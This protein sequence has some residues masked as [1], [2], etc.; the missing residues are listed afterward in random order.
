MIEILESRLEEFERSYKRIRYNVLHD[1]FSRSCYITPENVIVTN[2]LRSH[3]VAIFNPGGALLGNGTVLIFPRL[4]FD[5]YTYNSSIGLLMIN[6]DELLEGKLHNPLQCEI[7]LWPE[8]LWEFGHGCEDAR[9]H[10]HEDLVYLLYTGSKHYHDESGSLV[11]QSVQALA[12]FDLNAQDRHAEK[13]GYFSVKCEDE[14]SFLVGCKDSAFLEFKPPAVSMLLRL[15]V[16]R[17]L[18][19]WRGE[20]DIS[21]MTL[22]IDSL[23]PVM[24]PE[25]WETKIGWSTNAVEYAPGEYLIGWHAVLREDLSYRNGLAVVNE[26]GELLAI[27]DYL[28]A[29]RGLN[30]WYG[31]RAGVIFG[32][33][34]IKHEDK[35]IWIGGVSDYA[36]GVFVVDLDRAL[37]YLRSI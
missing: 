34:L 1:I 5:Y 4:V 10:V 23:H 21:T 9:A 13:R 29:P 14:K 11:K 6:I 25:D 15:D 32:D 35:L 30:E 24:S 8:K 19:C 2:Y 17:R 12:V 27:S 28:L 37:F 33:T 31:D 20:G 3:P 26:K 16:G 18:A 36:I 7:V 22:S